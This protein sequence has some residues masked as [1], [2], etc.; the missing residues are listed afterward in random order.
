MLARALLY[1]LLLCSSAA[2]AQRVNCNLFVKKSKRLLQT[3]V[4]QSDSALTVFHEGDIT[5]TLMINDAAKRE[6]INFDFVF[7]DSRGRGAEMSDILTIHFDHYKAEFIAREKRI[8][9]GKMTFAIIRQTE[10][11]L[12]TVL[13]EEDALFYQKLQTELI[14]Y[15]ELKINGQPQKM[16]LTAQQSQWLRDVMICLSK[17]VNY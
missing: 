9:S 6:T 15:F 11:R 8:Y 3:S 4:Y 13:T 17:R 14:T 12:G 2:V 1:S 5:G 10:T 16:Y 7:A